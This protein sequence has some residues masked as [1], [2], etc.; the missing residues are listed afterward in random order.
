MAKS[1]RVPFQ[2]TGGK[3]ADTKEYSRQ[4]EQKI[5]N[6]L[7]ISKLERIMIPNYGAGVQQLLFDNIDELVEVDFK[8]DAVAEVLARVSGVTVVDVRVYQEN[9]TTARVTVYYRTP[10]SSVTSTTFSV[11]IPGNL[12]EESPL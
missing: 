4:V 1:L 11:V 5:I 7:V 12:T 10:L 6:V 2:V 3:I 8:T 9:D